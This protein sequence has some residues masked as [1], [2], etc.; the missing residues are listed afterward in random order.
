MHLHTAENVREIL[1]ESEMS[2]QRPEGGDASGDVNDKRNDDQPATG[3]AEQSSDFA[4]R[5]IGYFS[6]HSRKFSMLLAGRDALYQEAHLSGC[7]IK[8]KYEKNYDKKEGGCSQQTRMEFRRDLF[9][10]CECAGQ[11]T[12]KLFVKSKRQTRSRLK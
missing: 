11:V 1:K 5:M 4:P 7:T 9:L 3:I 8:K 6:H 12:R 10:L 2:N